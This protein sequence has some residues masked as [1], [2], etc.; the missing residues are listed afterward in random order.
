[1]ASEWK[2]TLKSDG[3]DKILEDNRQYAGKVIRKTGRAA[4]EYVR[5]EAPKD[6]GFLASSIEGEEG[7][8]VYHLKIGAYYWKFV[9]NGTRYIAPRYFLES[10]INRAIS[11]FHSQLAAYWK[12]KS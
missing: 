8:L 10:G 12:R 11:D 7:T 1:M 3:F 6:K 4:V 9:N 2:V 5:E